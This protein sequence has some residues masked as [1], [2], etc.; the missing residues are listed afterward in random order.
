MDPGF[1]KHDRKVSPRVRA[2]FLSVFS[3]WWLREI[4]T[5]GFRRQLE[6][7][8][9]YVP[10]DNHVA[11]KLGDRCEEEWFK[12]LKKDKPSLIRLLVKLY[13]VRLIVLNILFSV[14]DV[15]LR[16]SQPICLGVV[17]S[18]FSPGQTT[19]S[20]DEAML[21]ASGIVSSMFIN[22]IILHPFLLDMMYISMRLR[23]ACCSLIYRKVL[24]LDLKTP[25]SEGEG[26]SG[27]V[28]NLL[29]ND[30]S[31]FELCCI[32]F[33]EVWRAPIESIIVIYIMYYNIGPACLIGVAFLLCFIPLQSWLSRIGAGLRRRTAFRTDYRIRLM[34]EVI[35]GIQMIKMYAW[36]NCFKDKIGHA[37]RKEMNLIRKTTWIK[38]VTL[39]CVKLNTR[40]SIFISIIAYIF[41]GN[42]ITAS[43]IFVLFALYDLIKLTLVEFFPM[44][45]MN[46]MEA[47]ISA[48][49][50][51]E[52]LLLPEVNQ[53]NHLN[54]TNLEMNMIKFGMSESKDTRNAFS[55][56]E[57]QNNEDNLINREYVKSDYVLALKNVNAVWESKDISSDKEIIAL[58]NISLSVSSGELVAIV[59][60]VGSGKSVLFN[61][62]I[63][64][65]PLQ[66]GSL[67]INGNVSYCSQSAWLFEASIRQNILFGL[68]MIPHRYKQVLKCCQLET[69]LKSFP[70]GDKTIV[71]ERGI[72]LSGGQKARVSLARCVYRDADLYLLDDP[73]S[74]VDT[75]V[76]HGLMISCVQGFLRSK[77]VVLITHQIQLVSSADKICVM[78]SGKI[79]F[80][81]TYEKFKQSPF[82]LTTR[83]STNAENEQ[84]KPAP[85]EQETLDDHFGN[86][87]VS[88]SSINSIKS[89]EQEREQESQQGGSVNMEVYKSF[90]K[91]FHG[92]G[93]LIFTLILYILSQTAYSLCDWW[94]SVWVNL[95]EVANSVVISDANNTANITEELQANSSFEWNSES[96]SISFAGANSWNLN[97]NECVY[98]YSAIIGI[99]VFLTL[100]KFILF[101]ATCIKASINLHDSMFMGVTRATMWFFNN[102]ASGRILNRFS[103]DIGTVDTLLPPTL[104]DCISFFLETVGI[105]VVIC[106]VNYWLLA[107]TSIILLILLVIRSVYISSGRSL[108]RLEGI[109]RSPAF[110]HVNATMNGLDTIRSSFSQKMLIKEFDRFMDLHTSVWTMILNTNRAFALWMDI[111]CCLYIAIVTFSFFFMSSDVVLGGKVGLAVTQVIGLIGMCQWGMRQTA[112]VENQMT[113]VER[114]SEYTKLPSEPPLETDE[115]QFTKM[116]PDISLKNW[117][118]QGD[119]EFKNVYL[120]Y[121]KSSDPKYVLKDVN[122][123]V[124]AGE[125]VGIVGRTGAGKSSIIAALFRLTD[126]EGA[127]VLDGVES[128]SLG[129][130]NLRP[131]MS[132]IPQE[133]M[134][135][136][137]SL[138]D[139]LD[140]WGQ[141]DDGQLWAVLDEVEL[142]TAISNM[143]AGLNMKVADGGGNF[144]AGQRQLLCLAR[145]ALRNTQ[146]L[147]LD[148]ATANVDPETDKLIQITIRKK[149]TDKTVLTIAHRLHTVMD[150]DKVLVMDGGRVVEFGH[151]YELL[152]KEGTFSCRSV[153]SSH[154]MAI[155]EEKSDSNN[156]INADS[157]LSGG[158]F[159]SLVKQTG[160]STYNMLL[161][162]AEESYKDMYSTKK[163]N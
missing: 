58:D 80:D 32:F 82:D 141:Y 140:P 114:I 5:K 67:K 61:S 85:I 33:M 63:G 144:S 1:Y 49:R 8:D 66:S 139:N 94:I 133:P 31:R 109:S 102:N 43:K 134:L 17:I 77:A 125:K 47:Y 136:S 22:T 24:R 76:A 106:A 71:G 83:F 111:V 95:E 151:P 161:K 107:P 10:L 120:T 97:R 26:L 46:I 64:E 92:V 74:A 147:L 28:V 73:L 101:F 21:Y 137:G 112:E 27:R 159:K 129:L 138:R 155:N 86:R 15:V 78:D 42:Q 44:S 55:V 38:A 25:S 41:L 162:I 91:S 89:A 2:N 57:K 18:Y 52:F 88:V 132:I 131:A 119:L 150:S 127:I 122:F 14:V 121:D 87:R 115:N 98:I 160:E 23:T 34:N 59:G 68:E 130:H 3:F 70:H 128:K 100:T 36:E 152:T 75:K 145:A 48:H 153:S 16:I 158:I 157:S 6:I 12:E 124:K 60:I 11:S 110:T 90:M 113:S 40:I 149:F 29:T 19:I 53:S 65:I 93:V 4:F 96:W 9:L 142:K 7:D 163:D 105:L 108:K 69:D 117:P 54:S 79:V 104:A 154:L 143:P 35:Q 30:A 45:L 56:F 37:R 13:G 123:N 118:K 72:S 135:F 84:K 126:T 81:D 116:Y 156:S 99:G 103:K 148:E 146:F 62:I 20:R 39:C 51:Q 50:I